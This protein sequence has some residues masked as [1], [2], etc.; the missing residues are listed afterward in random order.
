MRGAIVLLA[1]LAFTAAANAAPPA[2]TASA[3]P[4]AGIA[5]LRVTL[6]AAGDAASYSWSLGDGATAEGPVVSHTYA[7]GGHT[8]TVTATNA[9]GEVSE[10]RVTVT[11]AARTLALRA[12]PRAGFGEAAVLTGSLRPAVRGARVQIY[13]GRTFVTS[14]RAGIAGA[15]RVRVLLRSPGPYH[16]RYGA[17]R[18]AERAVRL[19]PSIEAPLLATAH[20][21]AALT[22]HPRLV[23][24]AAGALTVRVNGKP[25]AARGGAVKLPTETPGTIRV[26]LVSQPRLGYAQVRRIVTA[27]VVLPTLAKGA[28][29][30]S[31]LAL[32]R[33][34]AELRYALRRVD[35]VYDHDTFEA[36][37]AFQKV[38]GLPRTGRVEGWLWRRLALSG[39]PKALR[40][41][42]YI[43][44]DKTRQVLFV[45]RGGAVTKV[46]HVS[47]G[48][49]GNTPLGSWRVYRKV[50][51]WDWVLWYPL[52]FKGG[53]AIHGYPSV[54][55]YPASHG[56]VRIP[57]WIAPSLFG[58]HGYGTT[59]VVH[60]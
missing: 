15:F 46:V 43:E 7:A 60:L 1:G 37:L 54:P 34:L 47:T 9:T 2:V 3:T 33:R 51:G 45:V 13:R 53:F 24:A 8:A 27:E 55:A 30:P 50:G 17:A 18:S 32:E 6:T 14:A 48:A 23:P 59:E 57:M 35:G 11:V 21:G 39:V 44:V 10:A 5:P 22:L 56:C 20:V 42:D 26:E 41:G 31:V 28:H 52:Y 36:V 12:P 40:G 4:T 58:S 29:G 19:R 38:H 25:L 16:A 49:T